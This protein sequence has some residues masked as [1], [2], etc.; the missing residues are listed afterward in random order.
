SGPR[1]GFLSGRAGLARAVGG[2]MGE[3][4]FIA[5]CVEGRPLRVDLAG[6]VRWPVTQ[7]LRSCFKPSVESLFYGNAH[8]AGLNRPDWPYAPPGKYFP[9]YHVMLYRTRK[10]EFVLQSWLWIRRQRCQ[11]HKILTPS[12]AEDWLEANGYDRSEATAGA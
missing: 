6:A 12:E 5:D 9:C 4:V 7:R 2:C 3:L 1:A 10:N 8:A 11:H